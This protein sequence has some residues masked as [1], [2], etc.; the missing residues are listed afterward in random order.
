VD[1]SGAC[2]RC[3]LAGNIG[4][5][6]NVP[7]GQTSGACMGGSVCNGAGACKKSNGQTCAAN[8][9]CLSN[10]CVEGVCC[11]TGCSGVCKSCL[12]AKTASADGTCANITDKTDPDNECT[13]TCNMA[14]GSA[15]CNG[16]GACNP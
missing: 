13:G 4:T 15:C 9:E 2:K 12:G 6:E 11:N 10:V 7:S 1:C 3:N 8:S 5:C 16:A 14:T